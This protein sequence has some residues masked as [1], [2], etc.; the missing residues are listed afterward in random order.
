MAEHDLTSKMGCFLDRHLVFP[1]LEFLSVKEIYDEHELLKGK[2]E[3]LSNTNM[4][5]FAM[6][7][8]KG[9]Y[10]DEEV[11]TSLV[12][13]RVEVVKELKDLQAQTEPIINCFSDPEFTAQVQSTRDG[14]QLFEYLERNHDVST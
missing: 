6:D 14:R 1:L 7:V 2:L 12:E 11:P 13:K 10:P 9:L 3:L 4:V 8:Y 5:D